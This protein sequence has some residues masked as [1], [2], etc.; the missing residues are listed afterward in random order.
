[1]TKRTLGPLDSTFAPQTTS[2]LICLW[3]MDGVMVEWDEDFWIEVMKLQPELHL[4]PV[5][6]RMSY[7]MLESVPGLTEDTMTT[8]LNMPGFYAKL[9]PIDA[10]IDAF[11]EMNALGIKTFIASAP[12]T[13][14][15]DC[16]SDKYNWVARVLGQDVADRTILSRD[17]TLLHGRFLIDDKDTIKGHHT[18]AWEHVVA[19]KHYNQHSQALRRLTDFAEWRDIMPELLTSE[20]THV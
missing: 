13:T 3:D 6:E 4:P 5:H 14:N 11:K 16:A 17:K 9:K 18:P 10:A 20:T 7:N 2:P 12:T 1:M 19:D 15:P 8:V